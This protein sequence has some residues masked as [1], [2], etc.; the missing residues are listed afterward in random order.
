MCLGFTW[1]EFFLTWLYTLQFNGWK[2]GENSCL[3]AL[4]NG[5]FRTMEWKLICGFVDD[6]ECGMIPGK[7][8]VAKIS[9]KAIWK[10]KI[11]ITR[12]ENGLDFEACVVSW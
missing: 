9:K 4:K 6:G 5:I 1:I 3:S 2:W 12:L 8:D 11:S 7:G 10:A